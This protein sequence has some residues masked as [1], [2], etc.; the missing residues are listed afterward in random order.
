MTPP[1]VDLNL[2]WSQLRAHEECRQKAAL[3]RRGHR[4]P[5]QDL[6]SYYHGMVV[7]RVMRLWLADPEHP[8][9]AMVSMVDTVIDTEADRARTAGDGIVRWRHASDKDEVRDFCREL[10]TRLEPILRERVLP[11]AYTA[12][13]RFRVPLTVPYIGGGTAT[14]TLIGE[15]DLLVTRADG[16]R[17]IWDL[18]GT[19]DDTY[20]RKVIG[21]LCFY[22]VAMHAIH[23][24]SPILAGLIQ[25]M[26]KEPVLE[27]HFDADQRR[28][29]LGRVL[30]MASDIWQDIATC[31]TSSSR[32]G[33][34]DVRHACPRYTPTG[35]T[36]P[37][38]LAAG[39][40]DA[41]RSTP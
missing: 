35:S 20:Y 34:C 31:T 32:C 8:T 7:D 4:N 36:M 14:I 28:N 10:V 39:L 30:R 22:D 18:K 15:L 41:A 33:R 17:I 16:E 25:P 21:Q 9:G 11:H 5:A 23:G 1:P 38:S 26:C 12:A 29:L 2:S 37:L 27:F 24:R 6:R 40:L 13:E 19:R 3:I